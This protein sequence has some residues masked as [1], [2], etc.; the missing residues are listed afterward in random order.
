[1]M[2]WAAAPDYRERTCCARVEEVERWTWWDNMTKQVIL[3]A[4]RPTSEGVLVPVLRD[5]AG[6]ELGC[7][8]FKLN[9][10]FPA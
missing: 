5:E 3:V 8:L 7:A 9:G 4:M 6:R 2:R 1:M 10:S